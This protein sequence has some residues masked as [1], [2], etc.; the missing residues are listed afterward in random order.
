MGERY[1]LTG[2]YIY[3]TASCDVL[4][5][6]EIE[7]RLNKGERLRKAAREMFGVADLA[8]RG[9]NDVFFVT[10]EEIEE[11]ERVVEESEEE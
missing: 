6:T 4:K 8:F 11:W 5:P 3:D 1:I 9:D 2:A 7:K 10:Q